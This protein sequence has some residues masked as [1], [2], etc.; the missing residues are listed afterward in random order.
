MIKIK[1]I[2]SL[3]AKSLVNLSHNPRRAVAHSM[4]IRFAP[5][6]C[7]AGAIKQGFSRRIYTFLKFHAKTRRHRTLRVRQTQPRLFPTVRF[8]LALVCLRRGGGHY[9]YQ[10]AIRLDDNFCHPG[11][12]RINLNLL[13]YFIYLLSMLLGHMPNPGR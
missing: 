5:E 4:D 12:E 10:A 1:K 13:I 7:L 8:A 2:M 11:R 9:R 3:R 6:T